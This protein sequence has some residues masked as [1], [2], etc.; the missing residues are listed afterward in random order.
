MHADNSAHAPE[1][2][3]EKQ[4]P[5]IRKRLKNLK[6]APTSQSIPIPIDGNDVM[7]L[8]GV[9][10]GPIVKVL[11]DAVKDAWFENPA[12]SRQQALDLIEKTLKGMAK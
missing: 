6:A 1:H 11:L 3:L 8:T 5:G 9:R 7:Q 10:P 12:I 4:I 2:R